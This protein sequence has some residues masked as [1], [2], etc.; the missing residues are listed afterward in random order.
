[1][2]YIN[3]ISINEAVIHILDNNADEP[4]LNDYKLDLN[5]ETY[6]FLTKHIQKCF[7]DEEL[8]YAIFN[9]DRNIVKDISQEFL[10]QE[11]DFLEASKE[12]AKQ[13][14]ILM[15]SKG[16]I[17]SCDLVIV[18][19]STEYGSMLGIMK[20][21]YIKNYFHNVE[22][23]DNKIGI[24][25][26]PQYTGLPGGG[27][28]IQKCAFIKPISK[29]N[30]FDL[31]V[32]D[33]QTKNKKSEEYG[34]NYFIGNYLGCKIIN[35]ERDITKSFVETAEKWTRTNLKEN[36]EAQ[37]AV[38][39]TIKRKLK[40]KENFDIQEVAEDLFGDETVVKED[41]V[42]FVK[43]EGGVDR[44]EVDKEWIEKKFKRIR[45]K[46]DKDIDLYLNEDAY[47][48]NSRFEI[49]RNG[50]GTINMIIKH[51]SNYIEK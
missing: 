26:I 18:H 40:E 6:N 12:L 36:A 47:N 27:Q 4:I 3:D 8:K 24:N 51:I 33:K 2:E 22:V 19:I 42:N 5:D 20:M 25:I 39:N 28:R 49:K 15:R 17:A 35:N 38:R 44:V 43:E 29:E 32:I 50:D 9:D 7:K 13:M 45:L 48:D 46:I 1:M 16:S 31:M 23:V 14:F 10:N 34:S 30:D 37:E 41:F 21:D 11:C